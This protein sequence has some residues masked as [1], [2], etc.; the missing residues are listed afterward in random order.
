MITLLC[1][2][3][4]RSITLTDTTKTTLYQFSYILNHTIFNILCLPIDLFY[5]CKEIIQLNK[6]YSYLCAL[7]IHLF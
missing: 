3:L 4:H 7:K 6:K 1:Q 2:G 5:T